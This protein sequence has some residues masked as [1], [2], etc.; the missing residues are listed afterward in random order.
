[1]A[2]AEIGFWLCAALVAY[3]YAGY[4]A[5]IGLTARLRGRPVRQGRPFAGSVSIVLTVYNEGR[6]I[7]RRLR[8]LT[9]LLAASG[10]AGEIVVVSDGSTDETAVLAR[11]F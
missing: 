10:R 6:Y 5:L 7:E 1:M 2:L 3:T 11:A 4:P 8:E 9:G